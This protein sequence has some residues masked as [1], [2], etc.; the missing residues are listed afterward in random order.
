MHRRGRH[1]VARDSIRAVVQAIAPAWYYRPDKPLL[2]VLC[3]TEENHAM[4]T[5]PAPFRLATP[6]DAP[7][8]VG[9]Y[10]KPSADVVSRSWWKLTWR[11]SPAG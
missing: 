10:A 7:A 6:D 1:A 8:L 3:R 4:I 11:W 9:H 5:L 2:F